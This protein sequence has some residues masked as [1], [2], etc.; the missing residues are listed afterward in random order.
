MKGYVYIIRSHKTE[1]V[2][3]GSTTQLLC[4]R[5][6]GHR[7]AFKRGIIFTASKILKFDDAYI[8][9]VEEIEFTNKQELYAREGFYIRNNE[10]VNKCVPD[11]TPEEAKELNLK[12]MN[13]RYAND[14]E[15]RKKK[16]ECLKERYANDPEFRK[17]ILDTKNEK[18]INDPEFKKKQKEA[19]KLRYAN[20]PEYKKKQLDTQ[21][22]R[23]ANDPEFKKR[24]N[25]ASKLRYQRLKDKDREIEILTV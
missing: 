16:I 6:A 8:E 23:Y 18:Y 24:Q 12:A 10:C 17:N 1:E 11:R 22:E 25:E 13:E 21:N 3:Y 5:M 2:Y 7:T 20:D 4:K 9:Q 14:I 19:T 15:F